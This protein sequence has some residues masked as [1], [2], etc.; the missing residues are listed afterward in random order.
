MAQG[1]TYIKPMCILYFILHIRSPPVRCCC[2]CFRLRRGILSL[3]RFRIGQDRPQEVHDTYSGKYHEDFILPEAWRY[4]KLRKILVKKR[5]NMHNQ[6]VCP[7]NI[8]LNAFV[9]I[10]Q[11]LR[12]P[13]AKCKFFRRPWSNFMS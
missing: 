10:F 4:Q 7:C 12:N 6:F 2:R 11:K 9:L 3:R 5:G 8:A 1:V 13:L